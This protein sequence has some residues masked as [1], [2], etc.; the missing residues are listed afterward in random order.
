MRI[1][2][3]IIL[4]LS[5]LLLLVRIG[6]TQDLEPRFL[7]NMP[8]G[9]NF[10]VAAYGY[11]SGNILLDTTLPIDSLNANINSMVI[12]YAKSFNLF[13]KLAKFDLVSSY[14]FADYQAIVSGA[15]TSRIDNGF[16]DPMIR[17]SIILIGAPAYT[18]TEFVRHE[19]KKFK[20][21]AVLRVRAPLGKYNSD[22]LLNLGANRWGVKLGMAGAYNI[23]KKIILEGYINTWI[24]SANN[25]FFN[26]NTIKQDPILTA[27]MHLTYVFNP[28]MWAAVSAGKSGY[29]RTSVNG[30]EQEQNQNN[31][32]FGMALAYRVAKQHALKV[33]YINGT[34]TRYGAD[35][36]SV[37]LAYQFLWFDKS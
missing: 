4:T 31:T 16:G 25:E 34:S 15:D 5:F 1:K 28:R 7:S 26:G 27:Q 24:F 12:G 36:N 19:R 29:G 33:A 23:S 32:R 20:L 3:F 6:Y 8:I 21:G 11:S 37:I 10:L 2:A 13:N 14:S 18:P 22:K 17:I 9:G 30:V 35:F